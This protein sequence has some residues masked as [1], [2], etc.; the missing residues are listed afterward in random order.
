[1]KM[2]VKRVQKMQM[3][4]VQGWKYGTVGGTMQNCRQNFKHIWNITI[5]GKFQ[6]NTQKLS[7]LAPLNRR[8]RLLP[9]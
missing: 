9:A 2:Y 4:K 1:M 7:R 5:P 6:T 8:H 3:N